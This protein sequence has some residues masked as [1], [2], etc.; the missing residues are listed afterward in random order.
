MVSSGFATVKAV[1]SGDTVVLMG[2]PNNGPPPERIVSFSYL[3]AP[4][5]ANIAKAFQDEEPFAWESR[6]YLRKL[7]IGKQVKFN[8][9]YQIQNTNFQ[10]DFATLTL[11]DGQNV[12]QLC[13]QNGWVR[14][15][16]KYKRRKSVNSADENMDTAGEKSEEDRLKEQYAVDEEMAARGGKGVFNSHDN[17]LGI[18]RE[19]NF[20]VA[21]RELLMETYK[22]IKIK[23]L[24]EY[25]R[26]GCSMRFVLPEAGFTYISFILAGVACPR[27][28]YSASSSSNTVSTTKPDSFAEE[29]KY[30]TEIRLLHREVEITLDGID[31]FEAFYGTIYSP[32]GNISAEL[33]KRGYGQVA[34]YSILHVPKDAAQDYRRLENEAKSRRLKVA[35][36]CKRVS[37]LLSVNL[38]SAL[39]LIS[40]SK[41]LLEP[42]PT[43]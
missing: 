3:K 17:N 11:A 9:D 36:L 7:I 33:I 40:N 16:E 19:V 26:D 32:A 15:N 23:A 38:I 41:A 1:L 10:R 5:L 39:F 28:N 2:K 13:L 18:R 35:A 37:P 21:N 6:E 20:T 34:D 8:I 22:G 42:E 29:A 30:F 12:G 43:T 31:R 14:I 24:C 25:V 27:M 4:K